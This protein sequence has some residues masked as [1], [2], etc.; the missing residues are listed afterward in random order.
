[1]AKEITV[2]SECE[3]SI[4]SRK[5]SDRRKKWDKFIRKDKIVFN[6]K[7]AQAVF[8]L[9]AILVFSVFTVYPAF[10]SL[11]YSFT[12][13]TGIGIIIILSDL[14]I[15]PKCFG[16]KICS[17]ASRNFLLCRIKCSYAVVCGFYRADVKSAKHIYGFYAR[18]FFIPMLVS[19]LIV[20]FVFK[21]F[22]A[23]TV[24]DET[25][26]LNKILMQIGLGFLSTNWL[27]NEYTAMIVIVLTGVWYQVGQ[28]ALIYL[29]TMQGIS[30][31]YYEAA[32]LDGAGYWKRT[33][34]ITWK[35][36]GPALMVNT[37]L[38]LINS[39]KQ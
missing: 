17:N 26:S 23:P 1:M 7:F 39:L 33:Y 9:P 14:Q 30:A 28:T 16:I 10:T 38:L 19:P 2:A 11:Y 34:H 22:Y 5:K 21:E 29:A 12:D 35:P 24:G 37:I 6:D 4:D 3:T 31:E 32:T 36:M 25:G 18:C 15:M 27:G 20:G 13:W 8:L